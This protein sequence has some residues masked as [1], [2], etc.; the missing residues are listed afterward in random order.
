MA[1]L[2]PLQCTDISRLLR[3]YFAFPRRGLDPKPLVFEPWIEMSRSTSALKEPA[4]EQD[5]YDYVIGPC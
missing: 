5:V 2:R 1:E 3:G 4:Q